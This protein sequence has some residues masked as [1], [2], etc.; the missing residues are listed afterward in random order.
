M[1]R[2]DRLDPLFRPRSVAVIGASRHRGSIAGEV[3]HNLVTGGFPGP[4]Y[5]VNCAARAVQS[6]GAFSSV[7]ELPETVDLAVVV[8]PTEHVLEVV[9][10]CAKCGVRGIVVITAGFAELGAEG[11]R[12]QD[13]LVTLVRSHRM[14]MLGPNCLGLLNTDPAVRLNATFAPTW[15]P[16]G[17]VSV[18]SQS[19]AVG[20]AILDYAQALGIGINQFASTG[21]KA[22]LSGNDFLEYWEHDASTRVILL[23]LESFGNPVRFMQIA[24][25]VSQK[26]PIAVVKSGRTEAGARAASSHTGAL[27]GM[28]VAVDALLGQ[29]GVLRTDTIEELFDVATLLANQP[30]PKGSRVAIVTNAGGPGIMAADACAGGG[31][32]LPELSTLTVESLQ[33]FLPRAASVGNPIDMLA[34]APAEHYER[35]LQV[36]HRDENVDATLVVFVPP[37]VTEAAE[38]AKA[39]VRAAADVSKPMLTCLLGTHGIPDAMEVLRRAKIPAYRFPESAVRA[40]T[41]AVRY[42][43]WLARDG[44]TIPEFA[45]VDAERARS[46]LARAT[47]GWLSPAE[48]C[49]LLAAY[50]IGVAQMK[51]VRTAEEAA[52]AAATIGFPVALKLVSR[53]ILHK[54]EVD[55]VRLGLASRDE[56]S[57][58]FVSIQQG[59][60]GRGELDKMEGA[61]V[62]E[63]ISGGVETYI[64]VTHASGF[65]ALLGFG[66]GGVNIELWRD[67]AFRVHPLTSTDAKEMLEQIRGKA[68][69]EGFRGGPLADKEGIV[70]AILRVDR[71]V[72][73]NPE[74]EELD[75]NPLIA[76]RPGHGVVAVDAR[77]RVRSTPT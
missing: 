67:V 58:A 20:L 53:Q 64:G 1:N 11:K 40:L 29:A 23:Y 31:L 44:G 68:L 63:M 73:D 35:V 50:G 10:E 3:F 17:P 9:T 61:L 13:R 74:I 18:A 75:I 30:S 46:M 5:P 43:R 72:A 22:D 19:G 34:S 76:R 48:T 65:G 7:S 12:L 47:A 57:R 16:S 15:P 66:I 33:S 4:V 56:V 70:D 14:H 41:R 49:E 77:I 39:I 21:N 37:L 32:L 45:N 6:V 55:G 25:R 38:V 42:A 24:R 27:A 51:L 28:D 59:L 2:S 36:V 26:K 71:M 54:T 69:L 52:E 60:A 62:Q 8:V